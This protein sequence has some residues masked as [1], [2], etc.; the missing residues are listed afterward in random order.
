MDARAHRTQE[1]VAK[2]EERKAARRTAEAE[3]LA[4]M[5]PDAREK[6]LA[7]KARVEQKRAM[8]SRVVRM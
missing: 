3:R 1:A 7:R 4:K 8:R 5:A 2:A 6:A